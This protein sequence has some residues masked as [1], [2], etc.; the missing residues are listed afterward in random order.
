MKKLDKY[1][2]Y[3]E[4]VLINKNI[5]N[6]DT[7]WKQSAELTRL[8]NTSESIY[9]I[10][11]LSLGIDA[12]EL[13]L[14]VKINSDIVSEDLIVSIKKKIETRI[15]D[16]ASQMQVDFS[17]E[18]FKTINLLFFVSTIQMR[19]ALKKSFSSKESIELIK[20]IRKITNVRNAKFNPIFY[21]DN[22]HVLTLYS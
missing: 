17:K 14:L 19:L 12:N 3:I 5:D 11:S 16:I 22:Q 6:E 7:E 13:L 20:K 15:Q 18:F 21:L 9:A 4:T 2:N 8:L 1:I 10:D